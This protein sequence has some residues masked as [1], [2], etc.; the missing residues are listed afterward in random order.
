MKKLTGVGVRKKQLP[1]QLSPGDL[2]LICRTTDNMNGEDE[3]TRRYKKEKI[4]G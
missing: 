2:G 3:K 4:R 1:V